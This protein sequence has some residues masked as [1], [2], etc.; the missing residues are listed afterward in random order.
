M[1]LKDKL[2]SLGLS[3]MAENHEASF[4]KSQER[5]LPMADALDSLA[6]GELQARSLRNAER[7][8]KLAK[9]PVQKQLADFDW[10]WPK[11][12][13]QDMVRELFR[14]DFVKK[15]GNAVLC[16]GVGLGKTHLA[17]ALA[18]EACNTGFKVLFTLAIDMLTHLR[19][20][21]DSGKLPHA[22]KR[23]LSPDLLC[24]DELGYLPIDRTGADLFFQVVSRRH[25]RSS[26]VVT[27]NKAYKDWASTFA[28]DAALTSAIL[29]RLTERCSTVLISGKSYR[30]RDRRD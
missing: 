6:D 19:A 26:T 12:L 7:R 21:S 1:P 5:K 29:D 16:G 24:V 17:Q 20:A 11:S 3:W 13:D 28:G 25:E 30:M 22:L 9:I 10:T 23:Y 27:T 18:V 14:L 15:R 4:K 2:N 8:L